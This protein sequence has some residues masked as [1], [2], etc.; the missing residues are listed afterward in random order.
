MRD[1]AQR[2]FFIWRR[3]GTAGINYAPPLFLN[4]EV[5][6]ALERRFIEALRSDVVVAIT[7]RTG[8]FSALQELWD[9]HHSAPQKIDLKNEAA[10][11][12]RMVWRYGLR[13]HKQSAKVILSQRQVLPCR[14]SA[15]NLA[16]GGT[17]IY[18]SSWHARWLYLL[19]S[20]SVIRQPVDR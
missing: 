14:P 1:F 7:G 6:S 2:M 16:A 11:I 4:V 12:S 18:H 15:K 13:F 19:N 10:C 17:M 8:T 9:Y 20:S 5:R 3:G